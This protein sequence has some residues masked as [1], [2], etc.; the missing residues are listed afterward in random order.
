[1]FTIA[2]RSPD[3][4][5]VPDLLALLEDRYQKQHRKVLP[6][7]IELAHKVERVHH[8]VADAPLGLAN[9]LDRL[10]FALEMHMRVEREVLFPAIR[11]NDSAS[12]SYPIALMHGEHESYAVELAAI[13][14]LTHGF[15]PPEGAC[16]SWRRLYQGVAELCAGLREQIR[17]EDEVLFKRCNLPA[18]TRCI[19]AQG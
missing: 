3:T 10:S 12:V 7:L 2:D 19:C 17:I 18:V 4:M 9:A 14:A 16:G 15:Q 5:N 6:E 1:M 11:A 13:E 8:G